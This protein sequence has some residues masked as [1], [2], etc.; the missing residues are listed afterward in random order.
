MHRD[1]S[2]VLSGRMA[3]VGNI[4]TTLLARGSKERI[5]EAVRDYCTE[6]AP[7]GGYVLSTSG[8]IQDGIPPENLVAM[9]RAVHKYGLYGSLG[10]KA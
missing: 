6:L 2:T 8:V 5:E 3:L 4:P 1:A 7:G 10:Q 9:A